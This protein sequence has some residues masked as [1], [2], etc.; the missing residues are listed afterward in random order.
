MNILAAMPRRAFRRMGELCGHLQRGPFSALDEATL[1]RLAR[2]AQPL[3]YEH[4]ERV[5]SKGDRG[6]IACT[7]EGALDIL[8]H[9]VVVDTLG[10]GQ[11]LGLSTLWG[12]PHSA[13]VRARRTNKDGTPEIL[14]WDTSSAEVLGLF[15]SPE[16]LLVLLEE[17]FGLI[18]HLNELQVL[19]RRR[20]G[21][22][23]HLATHLRRLARF[24]GGSVVEVSQKDLGVLAGYDPRTVRV[25][26]GELLTAGC[27]TNPRRSIYHLDQARLDEYIDQQKLGPP[28][29]HDEPEPQ[30]SRA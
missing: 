21:A 25:A 3:L 26:L 10:P 28:E 17:A 15:R 19:Y 8:R 7:I 6:M 9:D 13:E 5:W 30:G 11:P 23:A 14:Q 22:A 27:V 29:P 20:C 24:R 2:S 4:G 16:V 12:R 1:E 18:H